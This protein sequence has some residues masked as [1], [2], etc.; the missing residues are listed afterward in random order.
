M[1]MCNLTIP[2]AMAPLQPLVMALLGRRQP[3]QPEE[4]PP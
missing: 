2:D 1:A 4:T 3:G